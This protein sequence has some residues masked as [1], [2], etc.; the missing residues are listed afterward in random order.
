[1]I[2][3]P[4]TK[5]KVEAFRRR[6]EAEIDGIYDVNAVCTA[7]QLKTLMEQEFSRLFAL[8]NDVITGLKKACCEGMAE[9][10]VSPQGALLKDYAELVWAR[11]AGARYSSFVFPQLQDDV[12][13]VEMNKLQPERPEGRPE[14][15][16][17]SKGIAPG[18]VLAG[19]GA[20]SVVTGFLLPTAPSTAATAAAAATATVTATSAMTPVALLLVGLGIV[21]LAGGGLII[22][23]G[24]R[25]QQK[26]DRQAR[27]IPVEI[28]SAPSAEDEKEAVKKIL[29]AQRQ[30]C[31]NALA[32]YCESALALARD[33]VEKELAK[34]GENKA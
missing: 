11:Q 7:A 6:Q 30:N 5:A 21:M 9:D 24:I 31:K 13:K 8:Q 14:E 25:V 32:A 10:G 28:P 18:A 26:E 29:L 12:L 2:N 4:A 19:A 15:K 33:A 23:R 27:D 1:M 34:A 20:A 22:M 17:A 16:R 3:L